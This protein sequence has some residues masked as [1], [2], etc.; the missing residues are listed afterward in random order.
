MTESGQPAYKRDGFAGELLHLV[1]RS[2]VRAALTRP[3]VGQLAVTD[4]GYFPHAAFHRRSRPHGAAQSVLMVC[5]AGQGWVTVQDATHAVPAGHAVH[6]PA[7]EPHAYGAEPTDP[8]T[9]WWM[10]VAGAQEMNLGQLLGTS[11]ERPVFPVYALERTVELFAEAISHLEHE[12]SMATL[13]AASGSAWHALTSLT[14]HPRGTRPHDPV[15]RAKAYLAEHLDQP[16]TVAD[17]AAEVNLSAS[18]LAALFKRSTGAGP[19]GYQTLLRMRRARQLLDA[20]D[21]PISAIAVAV[22]YAD[23]AHFSRRFSQHHDQSPRQ[24]RAGYRREVSTPSGKTAAT[25]RH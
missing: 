13:T 16:V 17:L 9:I 7:G 5:T 10:H 18:H 19:M 15:E 6:I 21:L 22:G 8:W 2:L 20:S 14:V 1:P 12:D 4:C 23:P 11:A 3:T 25:R 24:Y